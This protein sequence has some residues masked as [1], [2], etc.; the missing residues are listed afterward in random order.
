VRPGLAR[1]A[2]RGAVRQPEGRLVRG[3]AV[4]LIVAFFLGPAQAQRVVDWNARETAEAGGWTVNRFGRVKAVRLQSERGGLAA[5]LDSGDERVP[6]AHLVHAVPFVAG[7]RYRVV[8]VLA[9]EAGTRVDVMVRRRDAPYEPMLQRSVE[10]T[11]SEQTV[12]LDAAWP[13]TDGAG[14]IR[15]VVQQPS[16]RLRLFSLQVD[17]L[18]RLPLGTPPPQPFGDLLLGMHVNKLGEHR[19]WPEIGAGLVRLWDTR[20]TWKDLAPTPED[21][22]RQSN[23]AW[24]RLDR[25]V[26]YV[27][28]NRRDAVVLMTLGQ[29]PRWASAS[30]DASC[31]YGVG[32]CGAPASL[33]AWRHYV[34][35]LAERYKG[36]IQYWEL[37]NEPNYR[38]FYVPTRS[39]VEL[40]RVAAEELKAVDPSNRLVSP[41]F[42]PWGM[43]WLE[44]FLR[45]GGG[46]FVDIVGFHWYYGDRPEQLAPM[47]RNVRQTMA[48]HDASDKPLWV[49]E[50]APH[51]ETRRP[52]FCRIGT[53]TGEEA[54]LVATRA[55][56]TMWLNGVQAYAYYTVEG[57]AGRSVALLDTKTRRLTSAGRAYAQF[58]HW[59]RGARAVGVEDWGRGGH[60]VRASGP[61]GPFVV[62]WSEAATETLEVPSGW[63]VRRYTV[64]GGPSAQ[65]PG[66]RVLSVGRAPVLL[67]PAAE[68]GGR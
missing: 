34:R 11:G 66:D 4:A 31:A 22:D 6:S 32:T 3:L 55:V 67:Q 39:L 64:L 5:A 9:G 50:G 43:G 61:E 16:A 62:A 12:E 36:R 23:E 27:R 29:P 21:F 42:T 2:P 28:S 17:D 63:N 38:R 33:D 24:Q 46:R 68:G 48:Q 52:G 35:V 58:G 18:G 37:W 1:H 49:T 44:N 8:L 45:D 56:L 53:M 59:M 13:Y 7:H 41:G 65:I 15:V 60:A 19:T 40:A 10:L 25:Y 30:P 47:I 26:D 57:M 54:D 20:T 51:C 14:D